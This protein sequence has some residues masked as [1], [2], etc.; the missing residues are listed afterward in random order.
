MPD[1]TAAAFGGCRGQKRGSGRRCRTLFASGGLV[2]WRVKI[3]HV[4][5]LALRRS[6][7]SKAGTNRRRYCNQAPG[8]QRLR[9]MCCV[10]QSGS[11]PKTKT[12]RY[13]PRF[14]SRQTHEVIRP[15]GGLVGRFPGAAH[16]HTNA[17]PADIENGRS[18]C[19]LSPSCRQ[20]GHSITARWRPQCRPRAPLAR[21]WLIWS[22]PP[23]PV[24][25]WRR[26]CSR[27]A[28]SGGRYPWEG[29]GRRRWRWEAVGGGG[30]Q[31][32]A[33]GG[34]GRRWDLQKL[35]QARHSEKWSMKARRQARSV[36]RSTSR[37]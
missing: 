23:A 33:V 25:A 27:R 32:E 16:Y 30:R 29:G 18:N 36:P 11:G 17:G 5:N 28:D 34:G 20:S 3:P 14:P 37:T 9:I 1:A 8:H 7:R 4:I 12:R 22:T 24:A 26:R 2:L 6:L 15:V 31:W 21:Q 13:G 35:E 10:T 19:R